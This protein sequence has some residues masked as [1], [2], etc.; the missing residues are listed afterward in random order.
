VFDF[1]RGLDLSGVDET[2]MNDGEFVVEKRRAGLELIVSLVTR[3]RN[4][5][6]YNF[7]AAVLSILALGSRV[8]VQ[9]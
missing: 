5:N 1:S 2:Q 6:I 7:L 3:L 9:F 8:P 4:Q